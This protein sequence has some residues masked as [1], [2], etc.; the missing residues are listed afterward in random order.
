MIMES[1][2]SFNET[3]GSAGAEVKKKVHMKHKKI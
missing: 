2:E 1:M 3:M